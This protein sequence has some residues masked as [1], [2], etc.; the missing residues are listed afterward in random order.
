MKVLGLVLV[1]GMAASGLAQVPDAKPSAK[2]PEFD[3]VSVKENKKDDRNISFN[4]NDDRILISGAPL[5]M[6]IRRAYGLYNATDEQIVGLT[7]W[8]KTER[9]DIE[10]KVAE[11]DLPL[12]KDIKREQSEAMMRSILTD[13][14]HLAAHFETREMPVYELV[15]A[16]K[17]LKLKASDTTVAGDVGKMVHGCKEGCMGS[18]DRH[19]DAKGIG[20]DDIAAFLTSR[21]E[22]TVV[23]KT[24]LT[25]KY[26]CSLDWTP[27]NQHSDDP[28]A[29][30]EILTAIQEQWGLKLEPSKGQVKVLVV[31]HVEQPS[32]N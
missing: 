18:S 8:A 5:A 13:R 31:D 16:K 7:G 28:G 32:A 4:R 14:F 2:V 21:V 17:G 12:M 19:L 29:P 22:K 10:A 25:G 26:D 24:G 3:V 11:E 9:F 6:L 1:V 30:P 27:D 20:T 23:D 15:V